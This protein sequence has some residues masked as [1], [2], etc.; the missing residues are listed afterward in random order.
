MNSSAPFH[1][2]GCCNIV[3]HE[4]MVLEINDLLSRLDDEDKSRQS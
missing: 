1:E 2:A 3:G 4:R